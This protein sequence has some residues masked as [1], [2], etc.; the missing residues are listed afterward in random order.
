MWLAQHK[1][2]CAFFQHVTSLQNKY[3]H[4]IDTTLTKELQN[5]PHLNPSFIVAA[6]KSPSPPWHEPVTDLQPMHY[7]TSE[8]DRQDCFRPTAQTPACHYWKEASNSSCQRHQNVKSRLKNLYLI[9]ILKRDPCNIPTSKTVFKTHSLSLETELNLL[10]TYNP[11]YA[12]SMTGICGDMEF[13]PLLCSYSTAF[14]LSFKKGF[15]E[16]WLLVPYTRVQK[17]VTE[18]D[19]S[20]PSSSEKVNDRKPAAKTCSLT[21][22]KTSIFTLEKVIQKLKLQGVL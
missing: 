16:H 2:G 1:K 3:K 15:K 18:C 9:I 5:K 10:K 17:K 8:W 4:S 22:K 7:W 21:W 13:F 14:I 19:K 6:E 11:K 12:I 20:S